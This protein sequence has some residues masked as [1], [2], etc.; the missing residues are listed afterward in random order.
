MRRSYI[1]TPDAR[2]IV[3]NRSVS[4]E[5]DFEDTRKT[6]F[7]IL[8]AFVESCNAAKPDTS[9]TGNAR[10][11]YFLFVLGAADRFWIHG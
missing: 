10:I 2:V 4:T 1:K 5:Y 11:G 3:N 6:A 8:Y 7:E 9:L